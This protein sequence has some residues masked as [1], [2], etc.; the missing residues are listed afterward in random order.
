MTEKSNIDR[1]LR[2]LRQQLLLLGVRD[3]RVLSEAREHL[4][5]ATSVLERDGLSRQDAEQRALSA[6][7]TAEEVAAATTAA[8]GEVRRLRWRTAQ[9]TNRMNRR[10]P[11][12]VAT[13]LVSAAAGAVFALVLVVRGET[14]PESL[15]RTGRVSADVVG[16]AANQEEV[17]ISVG[18]RHHI[19][20][21]DPVVTPQGL[22][23]KVSEVF[24]TTARV[25][26]FTDDESGLSAR[27]VGRQASGLVR[28]GTDSLTLELVGKDERVLASD[29][30]VTAT[31]VGHLTP[32]YP[33]GIGIGVVTAVG[34]T[35]IDLYKSIEIEPHVDF[36]S[37]NKVIVLVNHRSGRTSRV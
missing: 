37:L 14:P 12:A 25:T 36:S 28:N 8:A 32:V 31:G 24:G 18:L 7:G 26:L 4:L 16:R 11:L 27:V 17:T 29:L 30:V 19:R 34:Q 35:D 5:E 6:F 9:E 33:E 22:V 13:V 15:P 23:G 20:D 3:R 21:D 2:E 10:L 1:Y